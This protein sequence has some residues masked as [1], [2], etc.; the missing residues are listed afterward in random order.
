MKSIEQILKQSECLFLL[1]VSAKF[2]NKHIS[3]FSRIQKL[4]IDQYYKD[5][6]LM[7]I[8]QFFS[9]HTAFNVNLEYKS[10]SLSIYCE[11]LFKLL[12]E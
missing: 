2:D 11:E 5:Y 6:H 9:F 1:T 8:N 7:K 12:K 3:K 4:K 10:V